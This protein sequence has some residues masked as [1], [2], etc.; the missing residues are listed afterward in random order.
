MSAAMARHDDILRAVI[1]KHGGHVFKTVGDAFCAAFGTSLDALNAALALQRAIQSEDWGALAPVRVRVA[2]HTGV[3]EARDDDYFGQPLNRVARLLSAANGGQVLLTLAA[4]ELVAD[5]LP[6][7]VTLRDLGEHRLKDLTRPER[8][9]Q[10]VAP[11]LPSEFPP[12]K[13]LESR[14]NNLP[15]QT[16]TLIGRKKELAACCA[17]LRRDDVRLLTLTGPGGTGK[18]R[19]G[20]QVAAELLEDFEDGASLVTLASISDHTLVVSS[21]AQALGL[22]E[23][24]GRP[25]LDTLKD[26]LR[27]KQ[28]LLLLD[29]FEQVAEAAPVVSQ[30]LLAAARLRV[31]VTS[32]ARLRLSMEQEYQVPP[33]SL[34]PAGALREP[35]LPHAEALAQFE[36]VALFEARAR[37]VKPDFELRD[38]NIQ[39]VA[40]ICM[41]LDSLPL[42][43]E[44]AA[45][46]IKLLP[47]Q[48]ILSRLES[49][50]KLLTGGPVD[51]PARQRT[52]RDALEW[53]FD[54]L[55]SEEQKLFRRLSVFVGGC[56]IEAA[57]AV[58][59]PTDDGRWTMD[60][61]SQSSAILTPSSIVHRPSSQQVLVNVRVPVGVVVFVLVGRKVGVFVRVAVAVLVRVPVL[62]AM[63]VGV[64]VGVAVLVAVLVGVGLGGGGCSKTSWSRGSN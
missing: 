49:R 57:E 60:D 44:L 12:L 4:Q 5:D 51:L 55:A 61:G 3:A 32:R 39:V 47:P 50:L 27:H 31:L 26:H 45:A 24:G 36:A 13:T 28:M 62:V 40:E 53:S 35:P 15:P 56:T 23:A 2:L 48:V 16:T 18:T 1:E 6:E 7:D 20:L 11:D 21:I 52:L 19:L 38:Q 9:Y 58:C 59:N 43:I 33:L 46:R 17:L 8:V 34:P 64:L 42:A 41:R 10:L 25:L 30:L 37:A 14:P 29:N 63:P 22:R 54:L